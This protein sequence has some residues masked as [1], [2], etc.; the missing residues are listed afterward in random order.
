MSKIPYNSSTATV[1]KS[2]TGIS[3]TDALLSDYP[4]A[5]S[6]NQLY[7][8]GSSIAITYSFVD[9]ASSLFVNGYSVPDP[10]V[11][12]I[13]ALSASQQAAVKLALEQFSNLADITFVEVSETASEVGTL[14][15][16]FTD[17]PRTQVNDSGSDDLSWG[18]ATRPFYAPV[19]GDI[20][21]ASS[22]INKTFD[23]GSDYN[24]HALMH[25]IGHTLGL[26]H[27]FQETDQL[28][29]SLE[30]RNYTIMSYTDPDNDHFYDSAGNYNYLI[31]STPMVYDIAAIQHLYGAASHNDGNTT[32]EYDPAEPFVEAIWDSGGYD[33]LDLS[34]FDKACTIDLTPGAYST[35]VCTSWSM[36]DN[37]G[38]AFGT[39]IEKAVGGSGNDTITGNDAN[40]ILNG[41]WGNDTIYGGSG[42]DTFDQSSIRIGTD[43]FYG[44]KGND[45]YFIYSS[46]LIDNVIENFGEGIDTVKLDL[47]SIYN[48]PS[49]V[50]RLTVFLNDDD[51]TLTGNGLDNIIRAQGGN[52]IING[53]A[54][55]DIIY[56]GKGN[57]TLTGGAGADEFKFYLGDGSNTITDFDATA[58]SFSFLSASG[59][60]LS[61]TKDVNTKNEIQ[62]SASDGTSV[63]LQGVYG[64]T[65][66][67]IPS[68]G[69][70]IYDHKGEDAIVN[71]PVNVSRN[72]YTAIYIDNGGTGSTVFTAAGT[73]RGAVG[74]TDQ[75]SAADGIYV[76]NESTTKDL[77]ITAKDVTGL[78]DG[79]SAQNKGSGSLSISVAGDVTST[80]TDTSDDDDSYGIYASGYGTDVTI[81]TDG[82]VTSNDWGV[83]AWNH[84]SGET[85]I[86]ST[87]TVTA[88]YHRGIYAENEERST[89]S[90]ITI[91]ANNVNAF[92]EGITAIN[93]GSGSTEITATGAIKGGVGQTDQTA[94]SDSI[95]AYN[96]TKTE[97]ISIS[98]KEVSGLG[99]GIAS[100]NYGTGSTTIIASDQV[101]GGV[102]RTD[103]NVRTD[104]IAFYNASTAKSMFITA[105]NVSGFDDGVGGVNRGNGAVSITLSGD[106]IV[107]TTRLNTAAKTAVYEDDS[108]HYGIGASNYGTNID[109]ATTGDVTSIDRGI[110]AINFGS[111]NTTITS[112]GSVNASFNQNDESYDQAGIEAYNASSATDIKITAKNVE[113]LSHGISAIN[114]GSGVTEIS[115]SGKIV[116]RG[117][118][119][120][121]IHTFESKANITVL[122]TA[123]VIGAAEGIETD[124]KADTVT[125]NGSVTGLNGTAILFGGGDDAVTLGSTAKITGFID[126][127]TGSDTANLSVAKSSV[128]SFNY[129][130]TTKIAVVT[131]D[132][133]DTSFKDFEYFKFSDDTSA[134][135]IAEAVSAFDR[136]EA[137][138]GI[139]LISGTLVKNK[140]LTAD[141]SG[142]SD[143]DG[144]GVFSYQW[145]RGDLAIDGA[146][147]SSYTLGE[148]DVGKSISMA[149]SYTDAHGTRETVNSSATAAI[150]DVF[151]ES[152]GAISVVNSGTGDVPVLDFYLDSSKDPGGD[153]VTSIGMT[154]SFDPAEA[155]FTSFSYADGLIADANDAAADGGT[156]TFGAIAFS[157]VSIDKPLFTMTMKDLDSAEDF[158]LTVSELNIDGSALEGSSFLVG[159]PTTFTVSSTIMTRDGSKISNADVV[160]S[161]GTNSSSYK[162][163]ADGSASG[164]L[165]AGSASAVTASFVY[166]NS[167]KAISSQDA[168]DVLKLSVGMTTAAG[169][170]NTFKF[171]S[172]D[173]NQDGKVSSQDALSILKYSVGLPTPEQAKWVFVDTDGDYSDINKSNISYTEGVTI[174]DLSADISVSLT[175][176]LIGDVN[177]SYSGL[178]A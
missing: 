80:S 94:N 48:L 13:Y 107:T 16:G 35:I 41:S 34:N 157:P 91:K 69:Q 66:Y 178:I 100:D 112:L 123:S 97:N 168:L 25:E 64:A 43:T 46:G 96:G 7:S 129:N 132:S 54:G 68:I 152:I 127:G 52:D 161:D 114:S 117:S 150:K 144:L 78:D 84:G 138:I 165:T 51:K 177:D 28:P 164:A 15:F 99:Y 29:E 105:T 45:V 126:G 173:F 32:Y 108:H 166:S 89:A 30:Y 17:Y 103:Q 12:N 11:D 14:R 160:I 171:M 102:G 6:S 72:L 104:G 24:F 73:V 74:Q 20:W 125:V 86:T 153:G 3:T 116:G 33:T 169:T 5:W 137:P 109:I 4:K 163:A 22:Q 101:K 70:S 62:Y 76:W 2:K 23:R 1:Y 115:V 83:F 136:N 8:D 31:S 49:N 170:K 175:G 65:T 146:T 155:S 133:K 121:G 113:A 57:D 10:T 75:T 172:A 143:A 85:S 120:E 88:G 135:T 40:N 167:T 42:N 53:G 147:A 174:A 130:E 140:T 159:A 87:G 134:M 118:G 82:D 149:V 63:T 128:D 122:A 119:A 151:I 98:V 77:R 61:Y 142:I 90:D 111:G 158:G 18:W 59:N 95:Y 124:S 81:L 141:V 21:I 71:A 154:L 39:T 47:T 162:S 93:Y 9:T 26:A 92:D 56:S 37:L 79:I 176:I 131:I 106:V 110:Y 44:G 156:I 38:I 55:D 148:L 50:E 67:T 60:S 27:S 139:A 58:D 145:N 19:A 36:T